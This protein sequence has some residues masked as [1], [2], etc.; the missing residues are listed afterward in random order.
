MSTL[1]ASEKKGEMASD[2]EKRQLIILTALGEH[3]R[4]GHY[5]KGADGAIPDDPGSGLIRT[6]SI[7]ENTEIS[8][9]AIHATKNGWGTC[10]GRYKKVGGLKFAKGDG[11]TG[12]RDFHLPKYLDDL[13][14]TF[15]PSWFWPSFRNTGLFPRNDHGY[16]YLGEDC[17]GKRHFDCEGYIAWVLVK[18]LNKDKGTWRKGVKWYQDGGDGRL[19]IYQ[20]TGG[21]VYT[22]DDGRTIAKSQIRGGDILIRKPN[23]H[24][25]EHIAFACESGNGV[26]EASGRDRGVLFSAFHHDWTQLARIKSL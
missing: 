16:L 23:S 15:L 2:N 19:D 24:G 13:K 9:L 22:H 10:R 20:Y 8:D 6:L 5:L 4:G 7:D 12:D 1:K 18:A 14:S 11:P 26:L 3:Q 17:R 25:G 21:G